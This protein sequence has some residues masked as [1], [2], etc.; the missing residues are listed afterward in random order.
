MLTHKLTT[1]IWSEHLIRVNDLYKPIVHSKC[2]L[3]QDHN[4]TSNSWIIWC[5]FFCLLFN[6]LSFLKYNVISWVTMKKG[7]KKYHVDRTVGSQGR[8]MPPPGTVPYLQMLGSDH[9]PVPTSGIR[10]YFLMLEGSFIGYLLLLMIHSPYPERRLH[11][12]WF[13]V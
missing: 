7:S 6:V 8:I 13:G 2:L 9:E 4:P 11:T 3:P 5:I 10:Y 1:S 12:G